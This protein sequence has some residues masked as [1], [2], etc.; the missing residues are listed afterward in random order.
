MHL[1]Y[2]A[3]PLTRTYRAKVEIDN[4]DG[5]LRPG[6][7]VRIN[8]LRRKHE[9]A[10]AIPL[11]ALVNMDGQKVVYVAREG[12]ARML[13]VMLD[14]IIGNLVVVQQGLTEHERLIVKG[15]QLLSDGAPI[16]IEDN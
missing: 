10:I 13:P 5:Q 3:D 12:K 11:Y 6:M 7:I 15:Q 14:R 1:A 9:N 8:A 16:Q 2:K 4:S